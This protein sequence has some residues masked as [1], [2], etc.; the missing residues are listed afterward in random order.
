MVLIQQI[1]KAYQ[2]SKMVG[3][4]MVCHDIEKTFDGACR[5]E[6]F[7]KL[8]KVGIQK[9]VIKCVNSFL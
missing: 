2:W 3:H 6:S 7:D 4:D 5:I 1:I 9:N 8:R